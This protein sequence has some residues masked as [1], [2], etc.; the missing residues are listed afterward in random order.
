[1]KFNGKS[2]KV[3]LFEDLFHTM[4]KMQPEMTEQ[5]KTNHF[6][7]LLRKNALQTL[8]NINSSNRQTVEDVLIFL[9][10]ILSENTPNLNPRLQP[11]TNGI[12]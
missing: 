5:M 2:E 10:L 3:E 8:R 7:S 6:H 9:I 12:V 1:M 4:M 11:N